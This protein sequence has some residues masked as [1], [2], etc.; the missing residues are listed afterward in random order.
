[1]CTYVNS[2]DVN[3]RLTTR[4]I[5]YKPYIG[6]GIECYIYAYYSGGW[7]QEDVDNE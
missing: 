1:M 2:K 6:K 4:G 7:Y 5:V 3:F